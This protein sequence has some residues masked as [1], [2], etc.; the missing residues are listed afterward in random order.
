MVKD[1]SVSAQWMMVSRG[2]KSQTRPS[3]NVTC[4]RTSRRGVCDQ[5]WF[6]ESPRTRMDTTPPPTCTPS[7]RVRSCSRCTACRSGNW[8]N[9]KIAFIFTG[10]ERFYKFSLIS[11]IIFGNDLGNSTHLTRFY[12]LQFNKLFARIWK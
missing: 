2:T 11:E 8:S 3:A 10:S 4:I 12:T 9:Q 5:R 6:A 1:G 7:C